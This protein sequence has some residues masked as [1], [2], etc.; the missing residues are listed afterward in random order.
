MPPI[1][2]ASRK[3][4]L[5]T[6]IV[7]QIVAFIVAD[8]SCRQKTLHAVCLVSRQWYSVAIAPLYAKPHFGTGR[9]FERFTDTICPPIGVRRS[10]LHLGSL[11]HRLDLSGLVH[12]SSNSLTARLL[13]R[14]K[15]N[16][17]IFIAPTV[18]FSYVSLISFLTRMAIPRFN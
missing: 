18:S 6:E 2:H 8:E 13:G 9:A 14:V 1:M 17:E 12:H 16:L 5:P 3:A 4:Y 11:V 10:K 15:E 7:L